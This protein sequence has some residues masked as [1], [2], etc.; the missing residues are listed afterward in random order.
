MLHGPTGVRI[1][2]QLEAVRLYGLGRYSRSQDRRLAAEVVV[3]IR[4]EVV[5]P[6]IGLGERWVPMPELVIVVTTHERH[7]Q[8]ADRRPDHRFDHLVGS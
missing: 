2:N 3:E 7:R 4:Q 5:G 8:P 6:R 1:D